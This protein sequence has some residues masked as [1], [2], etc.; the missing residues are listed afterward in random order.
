MAGGL[1]F[2]PLTPGPRPRM[3]FLLQNILYYKMILVIAKLF[4]VLELMR[5]GREL[6]MKQL[7]ADAGMDKGTLCNLLKT[8]VHLG[9]VEKPGTGRYRMSA[10]FAELVRPV[11]VHEQIKLA[12]AG[13]VQ[14]LAARTEESGVLSTLR[15]DGIA[16]LAQAQ[17]PRRVMV[18]ISKYDDL[19]LYGSVSGRVILA[20]LEWA[21]VQALVKRAGLPKSG[22][23]RGVDTLPKLKKA[24]GE[25]SSAAPLATENPR[26]EASSFGLA[27]KDADGQVCAALALSIPSFRTTAAKRREL[28]SALRDGVR[29][30]EEVIRASGW[31]QADF[32]RDTDSLQPGKSKTKTNTN[33]QQQK[34][35]KK[36]TPHVHK[37]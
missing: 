22:D 30:M 16:V 10:K 8:L 37:R 1:Y 13:I 33:N 21:R 11:S 14:R 6:P 26:L 9:Y 36:D 32:F 4:T 17:H 34:T 28:V 19:S 25:V 12:G 35:S 27:I 3:F 29:E 2:F 24:L 23:W 18:Q 5:G 31:K 15:Q 20:Q 7:A